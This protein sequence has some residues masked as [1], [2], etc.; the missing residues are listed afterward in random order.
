MVNKNVYKFEVLQT[1][2]VKSY[3]IN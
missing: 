3:G 1:N 2:R